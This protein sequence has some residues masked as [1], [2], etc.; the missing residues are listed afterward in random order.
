ME[1]IIVE[2]GLYDHITTGKQKHMATLSEA[3]ILYNECVQS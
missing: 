1:V 2:L 3:L